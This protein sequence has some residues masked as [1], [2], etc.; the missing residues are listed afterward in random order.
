MCPDVSRFCVNPENGSE[1]FGK[2]GKLW[3]VAKVK[4]VIIPEEK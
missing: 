3:T 1:A 2:G 4:K